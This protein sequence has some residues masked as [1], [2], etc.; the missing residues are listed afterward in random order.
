[1]ETR[2]TTCRTPIRAA[3][4]A[5]AAGIAAGC[6]EKM[7]RDEGARAKGTSDDG[8]MRAANAIDDVPLPSG[9]GANPSAWI[10]QHVTVRGSVLRRVGQT[11]FAIV[12]PGQ[13]VDRTLDGSPTDDAGWA[14]RD[15]RTVLVLC[16][17][18][19]AKGAAVTVSGTVRTFTNE[20]DLQAEAGWLRSAAGLDAYRNRPVIV[21][22]SVRTAEGRELVPAGT[23][24]AGSGEPR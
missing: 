23:L 1:V 7:P 12:D 10:G 2:R 5:L 19:P 24:P 13:A 22:D 8:S 16:P 6:T 3:A 4:L 14:K 9:I 18:L 21:A 11:A 17:T 15:A 20:T